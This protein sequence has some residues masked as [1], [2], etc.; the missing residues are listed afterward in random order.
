MSFDTS[1]G[2]KI[3]NGYISMKYRCFTKGSRNYVIDITRFH[4][5]VGSICQ[6][7]PKQYSYNYFIARSIY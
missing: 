6:L 5:F 2:S 4:R 1:K 7:N 3:K